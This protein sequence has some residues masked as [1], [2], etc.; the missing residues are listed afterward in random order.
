MTDQRSAWAQKKFCKKKEQNFIFQFF[1]KSKLW[2]KFVFRFDNGNEKQKKCKILF[3]FKTKIKCPSRPTGFN[4]LCLNF[5]IETKI[6]S[7]FL[8]S[9]FNLSRKR[10]GTLGTR[11]ENTQIK[12][13]FV[14]NIVFIFAWN[15]VYWKIQGY[16]CQ[17]WQWFFLFFLIPDKN[18]QLRN[19][20]W[21]LKSFFQWNFDWT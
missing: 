21:K 20:I 17:K 11:I 7:L 14:L 15:V 6:K 10:N 4:V 19:Y 1:W 3:H 13:I 2:L 18:T 8:I 9:Y 5:S 16:W 12:L